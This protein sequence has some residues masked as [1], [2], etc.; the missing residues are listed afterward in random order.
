MSAPHQARQAH[1]T[2]AFRTSG[3]PTIDDVT[4]DDVDVLAPGPGQVAVDI[5]AVSLNFRDLAVVTGRYP[6]AASGPTIIASDG[7]GEVTAVGEG[8]TAFKPGDRVVGSF[9]QNWLTGPFEREYGN[10]ALGG[11]IDGVLA[12]Q[13][14]FDQTGLLP[15]PEHLSYEEAAT[16]PCAGLTA[17]NALVP[18]AQIQPGQTV[19]LLGSGGVSIFGLQF[20]K[21]HGARVIITSS[22]DQKLERARALG[23]D[24]TINYKTSPD[25][26]KEVLRLTGGRGADIVLEVGG[27][28]TFPKS[29]LAV[30]AS[31][32]IAVIGVLTGVA[33][34]VPIG[35]IG[36]QTL[37]VRGIFVGSVAMFRDMNRALALHQLHP[38]IDRVFPFEETR[39][40]LRYLQSAQHVGKVVISIEK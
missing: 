8:V 40:G 22:S 35:L 9:F 20:A 32:T 30:R 12:R 37:N 19:L 18:T 24:D 14:V 7:A 10:S 36:I 13:R 39:D 17:W 28:E 3:G 21:M 6:R 16:L 5:H 31:G 15:V 29:M 27:A 38:V 2:K 1:K 34:V 23:A 11:A 33:G 4:F 25:W 26:E